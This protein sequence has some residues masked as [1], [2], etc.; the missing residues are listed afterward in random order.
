ML[1]FDKTNHLSNCI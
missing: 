1:Q